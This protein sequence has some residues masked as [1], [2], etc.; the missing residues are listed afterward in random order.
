MI[1]SINHQIFNICKEYYL[2]SENHQKNIIDAY[3]YYKI[4]N[5]VSENL[6]PHCDNVYL[7]NVWYKL[8][9][10]WKN[11]KE[12]YKEFNNIKSEVKYLF[13]GFEVVKPSI[14]YFSNKR[15]ENIDLCIE[16]DGQEQFDYFMQYFFSIP[17]YHRRH[18]KE[19]YNTNI[20][21]KTWDYVILCL[22]D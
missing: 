1:K 15:I 19:A 21:K 13:H 20:F 10:V 16:L 11:E 3:I 12:M 4:G 2:L 7:N 18:L 8:G 6:Y 5:K 14:S 9:L 17:V 22:Y